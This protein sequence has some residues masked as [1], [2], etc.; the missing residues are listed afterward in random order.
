MNPLDTK[1]HQRSSGAA[2][3][4]Q[5]D[6]LLD[7]RSFDPDMGVWRDSFV[8]MSEE[9]SAVRALPLESLRFWKDR[10]RIGLHGRGRKSL[11]RGYDQA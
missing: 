3:G 6:R 2:R 5:G 8:A 11:A 10:P 9:P 1:R 4:R 7:R